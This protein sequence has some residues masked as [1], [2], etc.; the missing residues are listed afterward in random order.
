MSIS[1]A[2]CRSITQGSVREGSGSQAR[3]RVHGGGQPVFDRLF[4][5]DEILNLTT[6]LKR[7]A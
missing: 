5:F 7:S 3:S 4:E 2:N 1:E 6:S